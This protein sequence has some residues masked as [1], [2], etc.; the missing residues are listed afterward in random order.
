MEIRKILVVRNDRFG[1][2]LLNIPAMRAIKRAHPFA[3]ISL[4]CDPFVRGLAEFIDAVD[5]VIPWENRRHS[6]IEIAGFALRIKKSR[7][8]LCVIF[9]PTRDFHLVSFLAGIPERIGYKRKC[10]FLLT[11]TLN[12]EK[13]LGLKHEVE[14]N[15]ELASLAG[16]AG[17]MPSLTLT[18]DERVVARMS[19]CFDREK[20]LI[21]VHPFTSDPQKQW[22]LSSFSALI[23]N[24][25]AR[26]DTQ[27]A[28]IGGREERE[29]YHDFIA[30][31]DGTI[32]D[33]VGKTSLVELGAVLKYSRLLISGDSGPVHLASCVGTK[34]IAL[35][36]N[37]IPG[38]GAIRWGPKAEGSIVLEKGDL[39]DISVEEVLD[40][41]N[42]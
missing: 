37:D 13:Y 20:G 5:E 42:E 26:A 7:F 35:F 31:L 9:N 23:A 41:A 12:D 10:G 2:F 16:A 30:S 19:A 18:I 6:L 15:L 38:K 22:P 1:E 39:R 14:Y 21:A 36:R 3:R 33:L 25:A 4:S 11:R 34:T 27:V 40:K 8:D 32:I 28:V 24:L 29:K 17:G